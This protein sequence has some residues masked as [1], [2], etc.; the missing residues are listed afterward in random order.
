MG[1]Q[2]RFSPSD[3]RS[4]PEVSPPLTLKKKTPCS[5]DWM[6]LASFT[7][8]S[9]EPQ[10]VELFK[11]RSRLPQV[12]LALALSLVPQMLVAVG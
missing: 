2:C 9:L 7:P 12:V 3:V 6:P 5:V 11:R 8:I 4:V 10:L 1:C